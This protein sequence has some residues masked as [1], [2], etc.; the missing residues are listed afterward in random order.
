MSDSSAH[1]PRPVSIVTVL[2]LMGCFGVFLLV[3]YYGYSKTTPPAAYAVAPEKLPEDLAW[4]AT[5]ASKA[6]VLAEVRATAQ[7]Q[8][9]SYAWVDQK[10]GVFQLP[11]TRAMELIVQENGAR[12]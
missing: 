2:A 12:K 1:S 11:I 7:K 8:A 6:A 9:T 4:K 5:P 10:A 3:V